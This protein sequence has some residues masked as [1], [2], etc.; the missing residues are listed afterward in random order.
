MFTGIINQIATVKTVKKEGGKIRFSIVLNG[1]VDGLKIGESIAVNGVCQTLESFEGQEVSFY[2][3]QQTLLAT[4]IK[5]LKANDRVNI[6]FS[7]KPIDKISGHFVTGHIDCR[8]KILEINKKT[9]AVSFKIEFPKEFSYLL[10]KKGSIAVDGIS[11]T[12]S[13]VDRNIFTFNAIPQTLKATILQY[14][15]KGA[16]VNL[17]FDILAKY[18]GTALQGQ[19]TKSKNKSLITMEFLKAKGFLS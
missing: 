18:A 11:L 15:K 13:D 7:L 12:V 1:E 9:D 5:D 6:E 17:E 3:M 2:A 8:G 16:L 19:S 4:N 10:V 14:A